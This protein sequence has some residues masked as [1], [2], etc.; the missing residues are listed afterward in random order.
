MTRQP[1]A[2]TKSQDPAENPTHLPSRARS[3]TSAHAQ[4]VSRTVVSVGLMQ[5]GSGLLLC[6]T[7]AGKAMDRNTRMMAWSALA[8]WGDSEW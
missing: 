8:A 2:S 6:L 1:P 7:I 5:G 4:L 3:K